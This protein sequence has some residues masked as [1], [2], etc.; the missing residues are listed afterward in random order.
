MNLLTLA[1]YNGIPFDKPVVRFYALFILVGALLALFLSNYRAHKDGYDWHFFDTI[2][3]VAFPAG[4]IGSRIWYVLA[5]LNEFANQPWYS[6]FEIWNGGLAI[7]GGAI[8]G[9]LAGVLYA[10]FRR[11]G[12][13]ILRCMDFAVPTILVAQA[14]GRW[15][16]FFNQEVFGHAV[17][18][19]AWDFLPTF[20]TSN[21]Q[22]GTDAM[23]G[24][25]S[26]VV[27]AGGVVAPLFLIEGVINL[28]FYFLIGYGV[29]A[30]EGKNYKEGDSSFSYFIAYGLV[31]LILEPLR[32]YRFIMGVSTA[33][34]L[35]RSHYNSLIMAIA[36]IV[37]GVIMI[38]LNH[39]IRYLSSKGKLDNVPIV[40]RFLE[41]NNNPVEL[42]Y[43]KVA[44]E[45]ELARE[46][47]PLDMNKLK[48]KEHEHDQEKKE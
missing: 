46:P 47:K 48:A 41:K 42:N 12:T 9:I 39:I 5:S 20:I 29:P 28:F 27:P 13:H 45:D 10:R 14:I 1:Y 4:I 17:S 32:N 26:Y 30:L 2:F 15:G 33:T 7:Q 43:A 38:A 35:S 44:K 8:G 31:R 3:L 16:N 19:S 11:K 21:L 23:I 40:N 22:N 37:F 24:A 34:D 36:F 25:G 6:V 18:A